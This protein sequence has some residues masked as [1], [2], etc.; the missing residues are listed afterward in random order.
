MEPLSKC[1][2]SRYCGL[3]FRGDG[4]IVNLS[5]VLLMDGAYPDQVR[6]APNREY[7]TIRFAGAPPGLEGGAC[8]LLIPLTRHGSQ[9]TCRGISSDE[10]GTFWPG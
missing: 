10:R 4:T 6:R 1:L 2:L 3:T 5:R 8:L 7:V 9:P